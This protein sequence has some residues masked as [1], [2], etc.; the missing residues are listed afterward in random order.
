MLTIYS[1][2][3]RNHFHLTYVYV[4]KV[5]W[6]QMP[7]DNNGQATFVSLPSC[8]TFSLLREAHLSHNWQLRRIV[9]QS[10]RP[11]HPGPA[12]RQG[13][14]V[15]TG[16]EI[17]RSVLV[18][19]VWGPHSRMREGMDAGNCKWYRAVADAHTGL[20]TARLNFYL[21]QGRCSLAPCCCL[22]ECLGGNKQRENFINYPS[23][24]HINSK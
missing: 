2:L 8:L 15:R 7:N 19:A 13:K 20:L 18:F 10:S 5:R 11:V 4:E 12:A 6:T 24:L 16:S 22:C 17:G 21:T 1:L 14:A 3:S 9:Q 23:N